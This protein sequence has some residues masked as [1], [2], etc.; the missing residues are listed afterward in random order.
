VATGGG[1]YVRDANRDRIRRLGA[2]IL[3]DVELP[4]L[5]DRLSG[6]IDRPLFSNPEQAAALW[7]E[8]SPFYR[9]GSIPVALTDGS[10]EESA[11]AVLIALDA[12]VR[13]DS[14]GI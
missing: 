7:A 12:R 9:M 10:V 11:D 14:C 5:L 1:C 2:A 13:G 3:L 6:K 4:V 8:R